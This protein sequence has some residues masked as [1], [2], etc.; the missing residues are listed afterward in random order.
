[1]TPDEATEFAARITA[2]TE[3]RNAGPVWPGIRTV[4]RARVARDLDGYLRA[5]DGLAQHEADEWG[6]CAWCSGDDGVTLPCPD[7]VRYAADRDDR[8]E[9]L[10]ETGAI[11]GVTL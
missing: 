4:D 6:T 10:T 9:A 11:Y 8:L 5:L 2:A 3:V 1:M 7:A